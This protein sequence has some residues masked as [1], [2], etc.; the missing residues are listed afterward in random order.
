MP[1]GAGDD[2]AMGS[3]AAGEEAGACAGACAGTGAVAEAAP[4]TF[5]I[6]LRREEGGGRREDER[7][8]GGRRTSTNT[9]CTHTENASYI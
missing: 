7:G 8:M 9:T 6:S 4:A 5:L 1:D 2:D 3:V